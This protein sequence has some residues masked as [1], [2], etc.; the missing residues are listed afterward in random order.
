MSQLCGPQGSNL[1]MTFHF[2]LTFNSV[3]SHW[4]EDVSSPLKSLK[5]YTILDSILNSITL[6]FTC[7]RFGRPPNAFVRVHTEV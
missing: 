6:S 1:Y 7:K 4:T 5:I 3:V 2:S